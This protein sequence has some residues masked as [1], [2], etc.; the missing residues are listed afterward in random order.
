MFSLTYKCTKGSMKLSDFSFNNCMYTESTTPVNTITSDKEVDIPNTPLMSDTTFTTLSNSEDVDYSN[1]LDYFELSRVAVRWDDVDDYK[2][3]YAATPGECA[4]IC[5]DKDEDIGDLDYECNAFQ[6]DGGRKCRIF[7]STSEF[8]DQRV[9]SDGQLAFRIKTPRD[10]ES[11]EKRKEKQNE[12]TGQLY[13]YTG[14]NYNGTEK[15]LTYGNHTSSSIA[16]TSIKSMIVPTGYG[17]EVF[18]GDNFSG[19][20]SIFYE[21]Q[22]KLSSP[23]FG[24][25]GSLRIGQVSSGDDLV[26][27]GDTS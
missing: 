14:I 21:S 7:W 22:R 12:P 5:Y 20:S 6:T 24:N 25:L 13:V 17:V 2:D 19:T 15:A 11:H 10:K 9:A 23:F 18:T 26:Y 3:V 4:K 16:S 1:L 8:E 27:A